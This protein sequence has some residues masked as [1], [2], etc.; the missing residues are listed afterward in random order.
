M[1]SADFVKIPKA[2]SESIRPIAMASADPD[3]PS[4]IVDMGADLGRLVSELKRC[5]PEDEA[6]AVE[7]LLRLGEVALPSLVENFPGP[8]W[9]DRRG[10]PKVLPAGRDISAIARALSAFG[11]R[12]APYI[13]EMMASSDPDIRFYATLLA[14]DTAPASLLDPFIERAFDDDPQIRLMVRSSLPVFAGVAD[15][16]VA[17]ATLRVCAGDVERDVADRLNALEVLATIREAGS[18][19]VLIDLTEDTERQLTVPSKRALI[20]IT[21][22]DFSSLRKWR[23]WIKSHRH[24][25]RAQWL[26]E[27][28]MHSDESVRAVAGAEL[29][30]L[31]RVYHG[32]VASASKRERERVQKRYRQWLRHE[33]FS[34]KSAQ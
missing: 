29:Q 12:A 6:Q 13:A 30:K 25:P 21:G 18:V 14:V 17:L 8:L 4:I 3:Q 31:T 26:I 5:G 28:L 2:V 20:A 22:Q 34:P 11:A 7:S 10:A 19:D 27:S 33:Q 23:S 1:P 32:F 24:E 16:K 15:Y 9:F